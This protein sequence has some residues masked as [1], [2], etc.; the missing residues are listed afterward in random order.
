M[1]KFKKY[2]RNKSRPEGSIAEG[3][4]AEE[5][6]TFCSM[7]LE[8]TETTFNRPGR[9]EE[10]TVEETGKLSVFCGR[11]KELGAANYSL[12]SHDEL[13]MIHCYILFNCPEVEEFIR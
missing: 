11:G 13:I 9:N 12:I 4:L 3:F 6:M 2:I 8:G 7:Y 1:Y 10:S 5:C